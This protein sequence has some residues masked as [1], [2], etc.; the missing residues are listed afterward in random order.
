[1][2]FLGHIDEVCLSLQFPSILNGVK[3]GA[4]EQFLSLG[5]HLLQLLL[6]KSLLILWQLLVLDGETRRLYLV[7][8]AGYLL[9]L[10]VFCR[11]IQFN[12]LGLVKMIF[13]G[14]QIV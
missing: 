11:L 10:F 4:L 12:F 2:L 8:Q 7:L 1:M 3:F 13:F 6:R 14:S 9:D 5:P